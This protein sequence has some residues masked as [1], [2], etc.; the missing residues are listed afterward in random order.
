[1]KIIKILIPYL[2]A[3]LLS[4][5]VYK[6]TACHTACVPNAVCPLVYALKFS[7][8]FFPIV[9]VSIM[10]PSLLVSLVILAFNKPGKRKSIF[11]KTFLLASWIFIFPVL[12]QKY[13][14][15]RVIY[16]FCAGKVGFE[17][18]I[19]N[20]DAEIYPPQAKEQFK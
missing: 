9:A 15:F 5:L 1:M 8:I 11:F 13:V 20:P 2:A 19:R 3:L 12:L 7:L 4:V 6:E 18:V 17:R 10:L 14:Q 16:G